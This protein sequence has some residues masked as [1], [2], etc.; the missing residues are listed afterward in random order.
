MYNQSQNPCDGPSYHNV[1]AAFDQGP[2]EWMPSLIPGVQYPQKWYAIP[3]GSSSSE[4]TR[5]SQSQ[6]QENPLGHTE[7]FSP[8]QNVVHPPIF[9][10]SVRS[11]G[12]PRHHE[13]S[14]TTLGA[15]I[16]KTSSVYKKKRKKLMGDTDGTVSVESPTRDGDKEKRTK[17]GR[18]CDAC[19][20]GPLRSLS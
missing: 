8:V 16:E 15:K 2:P 17:T 4:G 7:Y 9:T 12:S 5:Q 1:A 10:T 11:S 6:P 20:S 14:P 18:A 19:V 3:Q 13:V